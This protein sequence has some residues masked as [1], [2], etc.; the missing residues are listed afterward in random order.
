M[1]PITG[2][3]SFKIV[4]FLVPKRERSARRVA[5]RGGYPTP[6][7]F[8]KAKPGDLYLTGKRAGEPSVFFKDDTATPTPDPTARPA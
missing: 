7:K 6:A 4:F 8:Y 1:S 3:V 5:A 2:S